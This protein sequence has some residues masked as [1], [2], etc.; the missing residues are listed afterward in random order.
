MMVLGLR[1][2]GDLLPSRG[3]VKGMERV[4]RCGMSEK[5]IDI[6]FVFSTH[7]LD[8]K[9]CKETWPFVVVVVVVLMSFCCIAEFLPP[10]ILM[11]IL[12]SNRP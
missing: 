8:K 12:D 4:T 10:V 11:F 9:T 6:K 7:F 1:V 3:D 5:I 2:G